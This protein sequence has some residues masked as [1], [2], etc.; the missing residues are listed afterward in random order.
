M[1]ILGVGNTS[2][3]ACHFLVIFLSTENVGG[4]VAVKSHLLSTECLSMAELFAL[5]LA[6]KLLTEIASIKANFHNHVLP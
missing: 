2:H 5:N 1:F 6:I 4:K 3:S